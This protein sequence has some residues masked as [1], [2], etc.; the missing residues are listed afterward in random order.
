MGSSG[1]VAD[2]LDDWLTAHWEAGFTFVSA[3]E[4]LSHEFYRTLVGVVDDTNTAEP[5]LMK[6]AKLRGWEWPESEPEMATTMT[7][8]RELGGDAIK[9]GHVKLTEYLLASGRGL[10]AKF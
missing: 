9:K 6:H 8:I 7:R 2:T 1:I 5:A 4:A 10:Q 3:E